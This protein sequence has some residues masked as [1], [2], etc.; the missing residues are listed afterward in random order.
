V[1]VAHAEQAAPGALHVASDSGVHTLPLQ[2]PFGHDVASHEHEPWEQCSPG[3]QEGPVP[4]RHSPPAEQLSAACP[5][6]LTQVA[7]AL[8]HVASDRRLHVAPSQQPL[9]HD[10]SSHTQSPPLHR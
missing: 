3:L 1:P 2:Q 4:Q 5:S 6:H 10:V 8:P 7:P 9:G